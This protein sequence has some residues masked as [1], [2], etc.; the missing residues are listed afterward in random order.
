MAESMAL[1]FN[2]ID[3]SVGTHIC[4]F[5]H[6]REELESVLF[7]YLQTG[8]REGEKTVCLIDSQRPEEV[9]ESLRADVNVDAALA[10]QQ[11]EVKHSSESY[12][13]TGEFRMHDWIEQ[14]R[15]LSEDSVEVQGFPRMRAVGEMCWALRSF[16]GSEDLFAYEAEVNRFVDSYQVLYFCLYDVDNISGSMVMDAIKTHPQVLIGGC[17]F[18]NPYYMEPE[19]FLAKSACCASHN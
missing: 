9:L 13:A 7:P 3:T 17:L 16:P 1:G 12:L 15:T 6:G 4:G 2:G 14:L 5:Y 10:A 11:L 8:V 19:H 18:E